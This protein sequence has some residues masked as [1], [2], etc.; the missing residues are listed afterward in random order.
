MLFRYSRG[1]IAAYM[2]K[3]QDGTLESVR[4]FGRSGRKLGGYLSPAGS[5]F[6]QITTGDIHTK[7]IDDYRPVIADD[8]A[9]AELET[10]RF[11]PCFQPAPNFHPFERVRAEYDLF[12]DPDEDAP[13]AEGFSETFVS[14]TYLH[15]LRLAEI[16]HRFPGGCDGSLGDKDVRDRIAAQSY[17]FYVNYK[18]LNDL[19]LRSVRR[20]MAAELLTHI[21]AGAA[22]IFM[23]KQPKTFGSLA[24]GLGEDIVSRTGF[25]VDT[26][27][28]QLLQAGVVTAAAG[29]T[30]LV[31]YVLSLSIRGVVQ[32]FNAMHKGM[33]DNFTSTSCA[34]V[35]KAVTSRQDN[36]HYLERSMMEEIDR[37]REPAWDSGR[38]KDWVKHAG[39]WLTTAFWTHERMNATEDVMTTNMK[40]IGLHYSGL[41]ALARL[42]ALKVAWFYCL[43][44]LIFAAAGLYALMSDIQ[45]LSPWDLAFLILYLMVAIIYLGRIG[46]LHNLVKATDE[47]Q[48]IQ[49]VINLASTAYTKGYKDSALHHV[50][51]QYLEREKL[52][53]RMEEEKLKG[54]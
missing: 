45:E 24:Q 13:S 48:S 12:Y 39:R 30:L 31:L 53:L 28:G 27:S 42:K 32:H 43:V 52:K 26:V 29:L 6:L 9:F 3:E 21:A 16:E 15:R 50:V 41:R 54:K 44:G 5:G 8:T 20:G 36:L 46:R 40:I 25:L 1:V 34:R 4:V 37:G 22:V 35:S 47:P 11:V 49:I 2:D 14:P 10:T 33:F 17:V 38:M 18:Q 23:A 19:R 51:S 7:S